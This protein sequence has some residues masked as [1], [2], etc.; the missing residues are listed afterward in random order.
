MRIILALR[1]AT[2]VKFQLAS[3]LWPVAIWQRVSTSDFRLSPT[4]W[5]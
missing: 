4:W 2:R 1:A 3:T 5:Y